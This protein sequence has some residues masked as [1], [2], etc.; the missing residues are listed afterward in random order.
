M[1]AGGMSKDEENVTQYHCG[2]FAV[3]AFLMD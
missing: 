1:L 3:A 2:Y